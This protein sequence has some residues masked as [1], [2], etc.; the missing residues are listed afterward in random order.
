V[1]EE[2]DDELQEFKSLWLHY[3]GDATFTAYIMLH[4]FRYC[5][6]NY[7]YLYQSPN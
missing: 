5:R 4:P 2:M 1:E 3:T 6:P 7:L